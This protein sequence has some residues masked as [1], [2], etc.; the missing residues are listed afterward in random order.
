MIEAKAK[1]EAKQPETKAETETS[2]IGRET[3]ARPR[4]LTSLLRL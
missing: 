2:R 1:T 4:G 3:E